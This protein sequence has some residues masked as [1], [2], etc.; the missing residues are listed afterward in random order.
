MHAFDLVVYLLA[1]G[2]AVAAYL[3]DPGLPMVGPPA[4]GGSCSWTSCR[5]WS[6]PSS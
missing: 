1:A 6:G 2:L 3:R 5:A 4:P